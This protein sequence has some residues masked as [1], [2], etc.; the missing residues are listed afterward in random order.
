MKTYTISEL[1]VSSEF[2]NGDEKFV[3]LNDLFKFLKEECGFE[4]REIK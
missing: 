3:L 1:Q 2:P 4:M